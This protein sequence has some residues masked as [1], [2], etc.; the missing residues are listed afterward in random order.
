MI[1]YPAAELDG[2]AFGYGIYICF[3]AVVTYANDVR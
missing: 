2:S 3:I 1:R